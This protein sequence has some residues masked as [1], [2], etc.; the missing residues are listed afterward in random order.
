ME[1]LTVQALAGIL[2]AVVFLTALISNRIH[3]DL[4]R[5]ADQSWDLEMQMWFADE[6]QVERAVRRQIK[7]LRPEPDR[8]LRWLLGIEVALGAAAIIVWQPDAG[9]AGRAGVTLLSLCMFAVAVA[10]IDYGSSRRRLSTMR[11]EA[12]GWRLERLRRVHARLGSFTFNPI[13]DEEERKAVVRT[14]LADAEATVK[15]A[16]G[17]VGRAWAELGYWVMVAYAEEADHSYTLDEAL[18]FLDEA[19]QLSFQSPALYAARSYAQE[20][21]RRSDEAVEALVDAIESMPIAFDRTEALDKVMGSKPDPMWRLAPKSKLVW[22]RAA[23]AMHEANSDNA[24]HAVNLMIMHLG[25]ATSTDRKRV[26]D[27]LQRILLAREEL[28]WIKYQAAVR[29]LRENQ[30]SPEIKV[31]AKSIIDMADADAAASSGSQ[32][33]DA[34]SS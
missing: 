4:G 7:L 8:L 3:G 32:A 17:R 13:A 5:L 31:V 16:D 12:V 10:L 24:H 14:A 34:A 25:G 27:L 26:A 22:I 9:D 30:E 21:Y 19:E 29:W 11:T 2:A 6:G 33:S 1:S 28:W 18:Y 20:R 23:E 15:K